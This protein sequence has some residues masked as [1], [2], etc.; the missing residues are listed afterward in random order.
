MGCVMGMWLV[1]AWRPFLEPAA[2]DRW[3][4][5]LLVP[6]AAGIAVVYKAIRLED[7][8]QLPRQAAILTGQILFYI[9]LA[10]VV[11]W[12]VVEVV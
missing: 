3:W 9:A 8:R 4:L 7:L 1:V 11:L 10:A 6:M 2:L 5:V 12:V